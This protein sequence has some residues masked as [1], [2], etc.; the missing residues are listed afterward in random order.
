MCVLDQTSWKQDSAV[1]IANEFQTWLANKTSLFEEMIKFGLR[2][3]IRIKPGS[4]TASGSKILATYGVNSSIVKTGANTMPIATKTG[5]ELM[6][7]TWRSHGKRPLYLTLLLDQSKDMKT[8]AENKKTRWVWLQTS[9]KEMIN[10][11]Y[12]QDRDHIEFRCFHKQVST[13]NTNVNISLNIEK[14]TRAAVITQIDAL[15]PTSTPER[16]VYQGISGTLIDR[17]QKIQNGELVDK[18]K[19]KL[20]FVI[21]Y[22]YLYLYFY[23]YCSFFHFFICSFVHLFICHLSFVICHSYLE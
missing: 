12:I 6:L 5:N 1:T 2:P 22:L 16:H 14:V 21:L 3:N 19:I 9:L 8:K 13:C 4:L 15:N 23:F 17:M 20:G 11:K 10:N 18:L 7:K